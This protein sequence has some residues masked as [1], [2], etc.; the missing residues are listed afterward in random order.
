MLKMRVLFYVLTATIAAE[1]SDPACRPFHEIYA[2]GKALCESM[3]DEA[4]VY[5]TD[6]EKAYTMWYFDAENPND[7]TT[8]LRGETVPD[9]CEIRGYQKE[10]PGP[11]PEDFTECH[12]WQDYACC[13]QET[14]SSTDKLRKLY[15][16]EYHWDRCGPLSG[17]CERFFVQEACFYECDANVGLFRRYNSTVY[18]ASNPLHND[19]EVYKMPIKASYCDAW[20]TA[21][22]NDMFCS[23]DNGSFFS[24]AHEYKATDE[25]SNARLKAGAVAGIII[26]SVIA[27]ALLVFVLFM[28]HRERAGKALFQPLSQVGN[29]IRSYMVT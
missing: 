14:T 16:P 23:S 2:N 8:A 6:E 26:A 9:T 29:G 10:T 13:T 24:C 20:F 28:V 3:F 1:A 15:G 12:P 18:N 19:W 5:E 4:F 22:R 11:E 25:S 27:V 7:L 21:C 17:S